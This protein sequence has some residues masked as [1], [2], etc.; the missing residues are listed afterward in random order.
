MRS[1]VRR[2]VALLLLPLAGACSSSSGA[3]GAD[4]EVALT[5]AP[6]PP[7]L[8]AVDVRFSRQFR[9]I[10][11]DHIQ[12]IEVEATTTDA[13]GKRVAHVRLV[14]TDT[15]DVPVIDRTLHV[16]PAR[17]ESG[18]AR[19]GELDAAAVEGAYELDVSL[20]DSTTFSTAFV[21]ANGIL[22]STDPAI[23]RPAVLGHQPLVLEHFATSA[24]AFA[25]SDYVSPEHRATDERELFASISTQPG[26][27]EV[28]WRERLADPH[29]GELAV[30]DRAAVGLS[31]LPNRE[32]AL[33]LAYRERA[34]TGPITLTRAAISSVHFFVDSP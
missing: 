33:L 11:P 8:V 6:L 21:A 5:A 32:Y 12:F 28:V 34:R 10:V 3:D 22:P 14:K 24:P 29:V 20:E 15:S 31:A 25:F 26:G 19:S 9:M 23:Q 18:I 16:D 2:G 30:G 7:G 17:P 13:P 27:A 1:F 4:D